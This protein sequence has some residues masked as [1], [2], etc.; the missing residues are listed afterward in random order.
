MST[1]QEPTSGYRHIYGLHIILENVLDILGNLT[2][3]C[4]EKEIRTMI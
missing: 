4:Y 2:I 3:P 1:K